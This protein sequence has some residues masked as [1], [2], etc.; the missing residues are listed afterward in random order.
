MAK[1]LDTPGAKHNLCDMRLKLALAHHR[2]LFRSNTLVFFCFF[3][4]LVLFKNSRFGDNSEF[5]M[6]LL[7]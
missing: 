3:L 7:W 6:T 1:S 4:I 5:V 2:L